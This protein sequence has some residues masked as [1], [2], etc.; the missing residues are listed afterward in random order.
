MVSDEKVELYSNWYESF[1]QRNSLSEEMPERSEGLNEI[2]AIADELERNPELIV[3][4]AKEIKYRTR[5][6]TGKWSRRFNFSTSNKGPWQKI[7]FQEQY[8]KAAK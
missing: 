7:R 2:L 1:E 8:A 4:R 3:E 5:P 6:S